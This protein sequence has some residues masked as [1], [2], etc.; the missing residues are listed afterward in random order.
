MNIALHIQLSTF[1]QIRSKM[2]PSDVK[3]LTID[4]TDDDNASKQRLGYS[5]AVAVGEILVRAPEK[6]DIFFS[7]KSG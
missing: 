5:Y 2:A 3:I 6:E 7:E 4:S 1:K